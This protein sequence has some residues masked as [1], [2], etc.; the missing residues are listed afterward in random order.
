MKT[1]IR[2][3]RKSKN[4]TQAALAAAIGSSQNVISKIEREC[5]VPPA[6]I[7]CKI[8][9][10]FHTSVDYLLY[11]SDQ[12]YS[13]DSSS[14]FMNS[15]I[16]EYSHKMQALSLKKLEHIYTMIDFLL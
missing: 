1:R 11:R 6:D 7:L 16:S 15:R 10:F 13:T 9:D 5:L 14:Q 4:M 12:R 2:E 3:L 8:A